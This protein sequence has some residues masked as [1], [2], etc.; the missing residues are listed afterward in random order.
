MHKRGTHS[1]SLNDNYYNEILINL[2]FNFA[3]S[4]LQI[5]SGKALSFVTS[6]KALRFVRAKLRMSGLDLGI[7]V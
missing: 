7:N 3:S 6:N 5:V 1:N 2:G 4:Y